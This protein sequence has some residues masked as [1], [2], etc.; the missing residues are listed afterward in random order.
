MP[1]LDYLD[2]L[3]QE[4]SVESSRCFDVVSGLLLITPHLHT[5]VNDISRWRIV[6]RKKPTPNLNLLSL[7]QAGL[8]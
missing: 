7:A 8:E 6:A 2:A 4:L 5:G 3:F 1:K